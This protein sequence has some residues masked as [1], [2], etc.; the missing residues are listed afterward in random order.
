MEDL[1]QRRPLLLSSILLRQNPHDVNEWLNRTK[2]CARAQQS[3]RDRPDPQCLRYF[4]V[5]FR[6]V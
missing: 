6:V 1:A 5:Q 4:V 2:L 3:G